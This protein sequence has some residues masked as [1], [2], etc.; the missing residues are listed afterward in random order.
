[1]NID[2]VKKDLLTVLNNG[3]ISINSEPLTLRELTS[4]QQGVMVLYEKAKDK[5]EDKQETA[6]GN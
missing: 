3:R 5:E 2:E 1:M 6:D 4:L